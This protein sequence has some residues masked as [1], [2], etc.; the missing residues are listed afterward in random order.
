MSACRH[1]GDAL[2]LEVDAM[3]ELE[4]LGR[5]LFERTDETTTADFKL[6]LGVNRDAAD[7]EVCAEINKV[8]AQERNGMLD[9]KL[10]LD[11]HIKKVGVD[12]FLAN[13]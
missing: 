7:E 3:T 13:F 6:F 1:G 11:G 5:N 12:V 8:F 2:V 4:L 10:S 9:P